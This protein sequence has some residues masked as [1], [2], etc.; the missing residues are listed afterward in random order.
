MEDTICFK[1]L[2]YEDEVIDIKKFIDDEKHIN[3][4]ISLKNGIV[5]VVLILVN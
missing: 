3:Y 2:D 1:V 4:I 5:K